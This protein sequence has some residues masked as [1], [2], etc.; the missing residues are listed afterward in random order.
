MGAL[1]AN[2]RGDY[3]GWANPAARG[4]DIGNIGGSMDL[5][6]GPEKL[7]IAME[8]TTHNVTVFNK[9]KIVN[10]LTYPAT[11]KGRVKLIFTDLSVLEVVPEGLLLREIYPGVTVEQLQAVTEPKLIVSPKLKEIEL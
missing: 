4:L 7:Y 5:C 3:A 9:P 10:E 8:H 11:T 6:A 2:A 1:Q